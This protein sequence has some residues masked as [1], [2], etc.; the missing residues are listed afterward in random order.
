MN[1]LLPFIKTTKIIGSQSD[2]EY[3]LKANVSLKKRIVYHVS[4]VY[5]ACVW[6]LYSCESIAILRRLI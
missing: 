4:K 5:F 3:L 1:I 6:I 2:S